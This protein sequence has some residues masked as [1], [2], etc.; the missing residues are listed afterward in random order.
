[1]PE[2]ATLLDGYRRFRT[3]RFVQQNALYRNLADAGQSPSVMVIACCDS[4]ADPA[5]IFDTAPGEIFVVRNVANLVPPYSPSDKFHGTS[6]ALEFGVGTLGVSHVMVLGHAR[7]GG[8]DAVFS[9]QGEASF[10]GRWVSILEETRDGLDQSV[11]AD[12]Q[13][14]C[15]ELAG[16][17]QSI[18]NLMTFRFVAERVTAGHLKLHG[19]YF[20]IATGVLNLRDPESGKFG[21]IELRPVQ[22]FTA[23]H[24]LLQSARF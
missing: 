22:A 23:A 6:A 14:V 17:G 21:E 7:C 9:K 11:P 18:K 13:R 19:C 8:I 10:I 4:R 20:D 16:I 5:L 3:G 2:F 24:P 12:E 1:M 15:L